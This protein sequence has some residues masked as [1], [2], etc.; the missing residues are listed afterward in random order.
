MTKKV[1]EVTLSVFLCV[2]SIAIISFAVN[3]K[4]TMDKF[5]Q[6]LEA[7]ISSNTAIENTVNKI[8]NNQL[9]L[10]SD[11]LNAQISTAETIESSVSDLTTKYMSLLENT[12]KEQKKVISKM[13]KV[14]SI[15]YEAGIA[16]GS[17]FM[18]EEEGMSPTEANK[19]INQSIENINA[20]DKRLGVL[21][22]A[23]NDASRK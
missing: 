1:L 11:F 14:C 12:S 2:C 20:I 3:A 19:L 21:S 22:K 10:L 15:L 7:K 9:K 13:D 18:E 17:R 6:L 5:S 23:L 16:F 8:S 4:E